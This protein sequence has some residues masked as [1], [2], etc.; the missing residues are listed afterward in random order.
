MKKTTPEVLYDLIPSQQTMYLMFKYT[1]SKQIS[2][3]PTSF[4]VDKDMDFDLLT[5]A[6]NIEFQRNDSLRLRFIKV[7]KQLKQYFLP[8]FRMSK[9]PYKFFR[10]EEQQEEFFAKDAQVPVRF[11]KGQ[12]FRIYFYKNANGTN[13]IYFNVSHLNMEK[14]ELILQN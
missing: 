8:E 2:Q 9:V 10:S 4:V 3:I 13:G 6:L 12:N 1:F 7:D 5:K 11:D 14:V